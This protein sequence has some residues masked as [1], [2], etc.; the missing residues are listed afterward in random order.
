MVVVV[1]CCGLLV[2]L[3]LSFCLFLKGWVNVNEEGEGNAQDRGLLLVVV[4][5]CL[6]GSGGRG[7]SLTGRLTT[8]EEGGEEEERGEDAAM[9]EVAAAGERVDKACC[10]NVLSAPTN[11]NRFPLTSSLDS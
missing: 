11:K 4:G 8:G 5:G 1:F 7:V 9:V 3:C 10:A 2:E 6:E